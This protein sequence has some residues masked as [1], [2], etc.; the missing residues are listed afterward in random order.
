MRAPPGWDFSL[1]SAAETVNRRL[2]MWKINPCPSQQGLG[3]LVHKTCNNAGP[4]TLEIPV[5]Q[6]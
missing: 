3:S 5:C 4:H 1:I 2:E 6:H